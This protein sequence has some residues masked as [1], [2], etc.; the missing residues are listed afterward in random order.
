MGV[1][2]EG[3]W[4]W[5]EGTHLSLAV[6]QATCLSPPLLCALLNPGPRLSVGLR[7]ASLGTLSAGRS[8]ASR[9]AVSPADK[10]CKEG[11]A[12]APVQRQ[13]ETEAEAGGGL[14]EGQRHWGSALSV[15]ND[16]G[17]P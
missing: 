15:T 13:T 10:A 2:E 12:Q 3:E 7:L 17:R 16:L 1:E 6:S 11:Q 14:I 4:D 5:L 9:R 8:R